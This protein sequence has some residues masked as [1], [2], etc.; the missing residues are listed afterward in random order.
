MPT[1][2]PQQF[3]P[4]NTAPAALPATSTLQFEQH[5]L[6]LHTQHSQHTRKKLRNLKTADVQSASHTPQPPLNRRDGMCGPAALRDHAIRTEKAGCRR[7]HHTIGSERRP[8]THSNHTSLAVTHPPHSLLTLSA[9]SRLNR[10]LYRSSLSLSQNLSLL[11]MSPCLCLLLAALLVAISGVSGTDCPTYNTSLTNYVFP[12]F[13][14]YHMSVANL[15]ACSDACCALSTCQAFTFQIETTAAVNCT[16]GSA[17]CYLKYQV[18]D[19]VPT[20][21]ETQ[22]GVIESG[23]TF[24]VPLVDWSFQFSITA[25][26]TYNSTTKL[27]V[28][29]FLDAVLVDVSVN[30]AMLA[31]TSASVVYRY[32][33]LSPYSAQV[34]DTTTVSFQFY[35]MAPIYAATGVTPEDYSDALQSQLA[36]LDNVWGTFYAPNSNGFLTGDVVVNADSQ[37]VTF[38]VPAVPGLP[39]YDAQVILNFILFTYPTHLNMTLWLSEIKNDVAANAAWLCNL[40][41]ASALLPFIT[42]QSPAANL[43]PA[44]FQLT[45]DDNEQQYQLKFTLSA[46]IT[47]VTGPSWTPDAIGQGFQY[48]AAGE[49]QNVQL[50]VPFTSNLVVPTN[51]YVEL[52]QLPPSTSSTG[53]PTGDVC[54]SGLDGTM[55]FQASL[56][57]NATDSDP[58]MFVSAVRMDVA[59]LI[60]ESINAFLSMQQ[61]V[62]ASFSTETIVAG[63]FLPYVQ[64]VSP[65]VNVTAGV[66]V[67]QAYSPTSMNNTVQPFANRSVDNYFYVTFNLLSNVSCIVG[68]APVPEVLQVV[69]NQM[70]FANVTD[71]TYMLYTPN[72]QLNVNIDENHNTTATDTVLSG[73]PLCPDT[74]PFP[75]CSYMA[76]ANTS[77]GTVVV[78]FTLS[79]AYPI[80]D[81][82]DFNSWLAADI[83]LNFQ[84]LGGVNSTLLIP[85]VQISMIDSHILA[86]TVVQFQLEGAMATLG[87]SPFIMAET[88]AVEAALGNLTLPNVGFWYGATAVVQGVLVNGVRTPIPTPSPS[89]IPSISAPSGTITTGSVPTGA[90]PSGPA[91]WPV[92]SQ[93]IVFYIVVGS[94]SSDVL[95]AIEIQEDIALNLANITGTSVDLLLPYVVVTNINGTVIASGGNR[96]LLQTGPRTSIAFV[97]LGSVSTLSTGS[98]NISASVLTNQFKQKAAQGT[99]QTPNSGASAPAQNVSTSPVGPQPTSSS[100]GSASSSGSASATTGSTMSASTTSGTSGSESPMSSS[101]GLQG[102]TGNGATSNSASVCALLVALIAAVALLL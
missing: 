12:G 20:T 25:N 100:A 96:R 89:S 37:E 1:L 15:D 6:L 54:Q 19:P 53:T 76:A 43:N 81:V 55:T 51:E 47:T 17:C 85:F 82:A 90:A 91:S 29:W 8:H 69:L 88:F 26:G 80:L 4:H 5:P 32:L 30:L 84:L 78:V 14:I 66:S 27:N 72:A 13:D 86:A 97:L 61:T 40:A 73:L 33:R 16:S 87:V 79:L 71:Y 75:S 56:G 36:P 74:A 63:L 99:L 23:F 3:R 38:P 68:G 57:A 7:L 41:N 93:A 67:V 62:Q 60:A 50:F 21:L 46:Y 10:T 64:L 92:G 45:T 18:Q 24:S 9:T 59:W 48:L 49:H 22:S 34:D 65:S 70:I 11:A 2:S 31:N 77:A 94:I 44:S 102:A 101:T 28:T 95:F 58:E 98:V 39:V 35:I 52:D 42:I 83:V